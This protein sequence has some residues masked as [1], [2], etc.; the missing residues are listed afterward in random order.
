MIYFHYLIQEIYLYQLHQIFLNSIFIL[1]SF[2]KED[3]C[4]VLQ[5]IAIQLN[6]LCSLY[7][8]EIFYPKLQ[9]YIIN[10][11]SY[12]FNKI[13]WN[14]NDTS[15]N[16]LLKSI[17]FKMMVKGG[18]KQ[19]IELALK[20]YHDYMNNPNNSNILADLHAVCY[21]V[22]VNQKNVKDSLKCFY[23][24]KE[25]FKKAESSE[26]RYIYMSIGSSIHSEIIKESLELVIDNYT[27]PHDARYVL[28]S[29]TQH[30]IGCDMLWE[31]FKKN[32]DKIF[33]KAGC[34]LMRHFVCQ[35]IEV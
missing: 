7:E 4:Y 20:Y 17:V 24:L 3:I 23:E 25:Y 11:F 2:K 35:C 1:F 18:Y 19:A 13:D 34:M 12:M 29:V 33:E 6:D 14:N 22:A 15:C 21:R 10:L 31:F 9:E 26:Q 32:Y 27:R 8:N 5:A 30:K 16:A 28:F